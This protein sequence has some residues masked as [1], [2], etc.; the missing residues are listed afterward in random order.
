MIKNLTD[1]KLLSQWAIAG[2]ER[3]G[4]RCEV[5]DCRIHYTQVHA[6]H[7]FH[8]SHV[9]LRYALDNCLVLC[10]YHHTLGSFSAHKDPTFI[11]RIIATG[12]RS[13][14]WLDA[15]RE[16]RNRIQKNTAAWKMECYEKLKAYL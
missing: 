15:L 11:E 16:E 9:S 14:E 5:A 13:H 8:R 7:V 1:K 6:H 3:S 10:P 12:V 2:K 4:Y